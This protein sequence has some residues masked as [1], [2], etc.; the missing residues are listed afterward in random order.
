MKFSIEGSPST[1]RLEGG[2]FPHEGNIM[3]N[4]QPVCDDGFTLDNAHV[5]CREL[6]YIGAVS[7]TRESTYGTTSS[8]FAMDEVKCSGTE[9][10]LLDCPHIKV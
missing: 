6:G 8:E 7:F 5:A 4:G 9:E 2:K 1:I 10:R 3:V